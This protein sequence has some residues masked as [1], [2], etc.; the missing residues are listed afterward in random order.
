M[1]AIFRAGV[2]G[3]DLAFGDGRAASSNYFLSIS[4]SA[5]GFQVLNFQTQF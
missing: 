3:Y 4:K 5:T 2:D 1:Q